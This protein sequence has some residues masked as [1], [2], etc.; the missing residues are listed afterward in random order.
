M[1]LSKTSLNGTTKPDRDRGASEA[2][3]GARGRPVR[4]SG[5]QTVP[6]IGSRHSS[7][8][9]EA[10]TVA[11]RHVPKARSGRHPVRGNRAV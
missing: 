6:R 3:A 1:A 4:E 7:M 5:S 11:N 2:T 9:R 8:R 10:P